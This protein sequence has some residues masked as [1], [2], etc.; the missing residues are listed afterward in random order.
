MIVKFIGDDG[1]GLSNLKHHSL[2]KLKFYGLWSTNEFVQ[3]NRSI[4]A[5][6]GGG[7]GNITPMP[8]EFLLYVYFEYREEMS[9][10]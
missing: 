5:G 6:G 7:N 10:L 2:Y 1:R 3:G 4:P 9:R 8:M